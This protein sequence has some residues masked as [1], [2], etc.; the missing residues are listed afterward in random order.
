M[1]ITIQAPAATRAKS[2]VI[3]LH[4]SLGS[5][6]QW[7]ALA[8]QLGGDYQMIAPDISGY[9]NNPDPL[10]LPTTLAE[11]VEL[12]GE[13][14]EE[15]NGPIHLVGHSY[16]GAVAFKIATSSPLSPRVRSLTLIEPVLPTLL[17]DDETD[18][19]LHDDFVDVAHG[20]H[21]YL[22]NGSYL[23]AI[24][25]FTSFWNGSGPNEPLPAKT[26][27]RLMEHI[28]K[29]AF[30]FTAAL[31][32]KDVA[33]AAAAICVPTLLMSGGLSPFLT[34]RIVG[35]LA[36]TIANAETRHVPSAG[37]MMPISHAA[38]V[39]TEIIWHIARAD[40]LA[41]VPLASGQPSAEIIDLADMR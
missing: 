3:A 17:L 30:D 15:A 2:C 24:D 10:I 36:S 23:E 34:Q 29:L 1:K 13:R 12:L 37:H 14:L 38:F 4:R 11:E 32:E 9:G 31:A 22:W 40:E 25:K 27:I 8:E 39:N 6:R 26:R 7:T 33:Q 18:R 21:E 5:G 20:V 35:R 19:R 28:E 41:E 16:G